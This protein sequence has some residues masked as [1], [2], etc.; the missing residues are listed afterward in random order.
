MYLIKARNNVC[1]FILLPSGEDVMYDF[2]K[3]T[4]FT[5]DGVVVN[6]ERVAWT[7]RFIV[8]T[9][10]DD[11]RSYEHYVTSADASKPPLS[12]LNMEFEILCEF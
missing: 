9:A 5:T 3:D 6:I 8:I 7:N 10:V 11:C 2:K 1:V 12:I 4:L